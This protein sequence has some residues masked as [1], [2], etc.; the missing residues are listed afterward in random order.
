MGN[1]KRVL[2]I[3]WDAADWKI[4][5]DLV[6]RGMM[7]TVKS[8]IE[9]GTMGNLRTLSPVLSPMLWTSIATGKRPYK[10]GIYGFT[11]PAPDGKSIRPMTNMSRKSKAIWNILNQNDYRSVVVG[12]WPSH[13][14]EPINGV[15][16]SDY[17]HKA[18]KK[19]GD[20][21][22]VLPSCVHPS[23][24]LEE[25]AGFRIHPQELDP[26]QILAFVP[27]GAEIDQ[28]VD[29]RVAM[30][31]KML[32]ECTTVHNTAT[33]LLENEEW[34][35][36]A[37]YY[38]AID[39]FCH[40]FMKYHP[41][42][43][44]TIADEDFRMYQNV[45]TTCYVFH[46]MMLKRLLEF[47]NDD[48]TVL[49][50]SDHGFHPDHLRPKSIPAEPAGPA[51]E[52]RDYGIFL[53]NG[54]NV[55]SDHLL[56]SANL[57]DITPT[58]L[59]VY[60]LPIGD[61]M[62]GQPLTDIFAEEPTIE[63]IESWE[64]V[65]GDHGQH[66]KEYVVDPAES[67]A[68]MEQLVALGYIE[69]PDENTESA[70]AKTQCELD[71]NLARA[72]MD[73][74]MH[75]EA[76]P[77]LVELYKQFPLEFRF[78]IQ[79]ANCL[80]SMERNIELKNLVKDLNNRW[81]VAAVE[82]KARLKEILESGRERKKQWEELKKI[83][84]ENKDDPDAPRLAQVTPDGKPLLFEENERH[85]IRRLRA[86][87]RGN[88]QTLDFLA[89]TVASAAGEFEEALEF[90]EQSNITQSKNPGFL[91][92][93]GNVYVGLN[94]FEDAE[95]AYRRGLEIDE[96][97][98]N[99][100]MGLCRTYGLMGN[101]E[102][103]IDL[104]KQAI[105]LK[106]HFP[107]A[108]FFLGKAYLQTGDIDLGISS[109]RKAVDQNPNFVE[110]H[111]LLAERYRKMEESEEL[112]AEH[113]EMADELEEIVEEKE[114]GVEAVEFAAVSAEEFREQLPGL[115][116]KEIETDEFTRCLGQVKLPSNGE[117]PKEGEPIVVV[118]GLPRSGTSMMMQMLVA[119]GIK[120]YTDSV[121]EAD[122]NNPKGY[123][124]AEN[125]KKLAKH[126][127][128]ISD[129]RGQVVK[130]V[131]PLI[132]YLPQSEKYKVI[133]MQRDI[134]EILSSQTKMLQRLSKEGGDVDDDRMAMM[135]NQQTKLAL[136][137]LNVH[138]NE[139]LE[140]PYG[141]V[142]EKPGEV[143]QA[144]ADFL[145]KDLDID[146]MAQVVDPSLYRERG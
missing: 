107:L 131:A 97:H 125:T 119:G 118:S 92:H 113:A 39:H 89:A 15:M 3:G 93:V 99:C 17:F 50:V 73:A 43:Q 52:H 103:A 20:A 138:G 71:Y 84:D 143:A 70:I 66:S 75:G 128:W 29:A 51:L 57:L 127:T 63:S 87:A 44:K 46:D 90:L 7:P 81:R 61:D 146:A 111:R 13:P 91:F 83:D 132:S 22:P 1:S 4:I 60:G 96:F 54:P 45:V 88:P 144:M 134:K 11:E 101:P 72:Y 140:I 120:P 100:L 94:R 80:R 31:M 10:H 56:H 64:N 116:E 139:T 126:N 74:G 122:E 136:G 108:H 85:G 106:Y 115:M 38:D 67:Q 110:A 48:T 14:A 130:V 104:G 78:G 2:L 34:D 129:C 12:W 26:A 16:V 142:L 32:S 105:G 77:L 30:I 133:F 42:Q 65:D 114:S 112:A 121:R 49:L 102:K 86:I 58:I 62:D 135:L 25:V 98:P 59:S 76:V 123:Y 28:S 37:I 41:P 79:L 35:F 53:A 117:A 9:R 40:G 21:W 23:E 27:E 33:H 36:G 69:P 18:P 137:L 68:L 141:E 24:K 55:K 8:M 109:L 6:E 95:S 82:A 5:H 145:C 47:T 124:E 19:P